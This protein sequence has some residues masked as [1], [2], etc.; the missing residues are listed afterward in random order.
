MI[1]VSAFIARTTDRCVLRVARLVRRPPEIGELGELETFPTSSSPEAMENFFGSLYIAMWVINLT[2]FAG[3]IA[4]YAL[5]RETAGSG[6]ADAFGRAIFAVIAGSF[7]FGLYVGVRAR[8]AL[9]PAWERFVPGPLRGPSDLHLGL[10]AVFA[11]PFYFVIN[12]FA[13]S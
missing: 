5:L 8:T 7:T 3:M 6:A 13:G 9:R 12:P 2:A 4:G 1:T 10:I 11:I